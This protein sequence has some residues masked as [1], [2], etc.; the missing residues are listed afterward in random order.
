MSLCQ[1]KGTF[2]LPHSRHGSQERRRAEPAKRSGPQDGGLPQ[3]DR[4]EGLRVLTGGAASLPGR[5]GG[6][7]VAGAGVPS[8]GILVTYNTVEFASPIQST[9]FDDP[10]ELREELPEVLGQKPDHP[11]VVEQRPEIPT[12][13]RQ[14]HDVLVVSLIEHSEVL[15]LD[16][17]LVLD[18]SEVV[19]VDAGNLLRVLRIHKLFPRRGHHQGAGIRHRVVPSRD[20]DFGHLNL[21]KWLY[22]FEE[23]QGLQGN[24]LVLEQANS[25]GADGKEEAAIHA[26]RLY[27]DGS[28]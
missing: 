18:S 14:G 28:T 22:L 10:L 24:L 16:P 19:W 3:G 21:A 25:L 6:H 8:K 1:L 7:H 9:G 2:T 4:L 11:V 20:H 13:N 17:H 15:L 5:E 27:R 12:G 26:H 23:R